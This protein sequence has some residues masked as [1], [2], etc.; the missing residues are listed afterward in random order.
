MTLRK[1]PGKTRI[2]RKM[3]TRLNT[4]LENSLLGY[5]AAASAAGVSLMAL[6]P[7]AEAKIVYTP[8]HVQIIGNIYLDLNHDGIHDFRF[9][10]THH[11]SSGA[12]HAA[13]FFTRSSA[14]LRV[15]PVGRPNQIWGHSS[16]ASALKPGVRVGPK[17]SPGGFSMVQVAGINGQLSVYY[18]PWEGT[19]SNR[20]VKDHY[21]GLKFLIKGQVHYGW[22]RFAVTAKYPISATLTGYAYETVPNKPIV[23]GKTNSSDVEGS[24]STASEATG[25]AVPQPGSLG[26]LA[27]GAPALAVDRKRGASW[28]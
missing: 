2:S 26:L 17:F 27:R 25:S 16:Y 4:K 14:Q 11:T 18:G 20:T 10:T 23:T 8:A 3:A 19:K 22:A 9:S 5:A 1:P 28:Q 15:Y 6:S 13:T 7:L 12:A 21:V 24:E